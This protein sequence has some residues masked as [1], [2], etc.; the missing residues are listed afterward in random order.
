MDIK[1]A[2]LLKALEVGY[3]SWGAVICVDDV[4]PDFIDIRPINDLFEQLGWELVKE[5]NKKNIYVKG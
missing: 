1:L 5:G 3:T 2:K 4:T